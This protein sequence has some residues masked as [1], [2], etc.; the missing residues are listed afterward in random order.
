MC[1]SFTAQCV[2]LMQKNWR[3]F[4]FIREVKLDASGIFSVLPFPAIAEV[5]KQNKTFLAKYNKVA[6]REIPLKF[7]FFLPLHAYTL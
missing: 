1:T 3:Y 7:C 5:K 6:P 4:K 2:L